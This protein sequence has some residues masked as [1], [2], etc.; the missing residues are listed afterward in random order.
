MRRYPGMRL[1]PGQDPVMRNE[2]LKA[3]RQLKQISSA[4]ANA[5]TRTNQPIAVIGGISGGGGG[6]LPDHNHTSGAGGSTLGSSGGTMTANGTWNFGGTVALPSS[7]TLDGDPIVSVIYSADLTGSASVT[8]TTFFNGPASGGVYRVSYY[9]RCTSGAGI[10]SIVAGLYWDD[11]TAQS[12][13]I[14][15]VNTTGDYSQ[16]TRVCRLAASQTID[17]AITVETTGSWALWIRLEA[18]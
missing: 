12:T 9:L 11:G 6:A 7:T 10:D 1:P 15:V 17:Y 4:L 16:L 3:D 2:L 18:L 8:Q 13:T 14:S 5:L